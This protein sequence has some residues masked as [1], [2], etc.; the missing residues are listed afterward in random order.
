ML[1]DLAVL[2]V[3]AAV[4]VGAVRLLVIPAV[5]TIS[6]RFGFSS[7]LKGQ[8]IGYATSVPEFVVVIS[9]ALAGVF[10]A[11]FWNIASSNIINC[12]LFGSAV[13]AY[14]QHRDLPRRVFADETAFVVLSIAVP[15]ALFMLKV[16]VTLSAAWGLLGLFA[17]Y[18]GIDRAVN[19]RGPSPPSQPGGES[20]A[21]SLLKAL[22]A[23]AL[24]IGIV[25]VAGRFLGRSAHGLVTRLGTPAW[26]V[27][28]ILGFITSI[29]ELTSFFEIYRLHKKRKSLHL[30]LDT[31]EGLDALVASNMCNLGL[32]LPIGM[33]VY[34]WVR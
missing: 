28:W 15:A 17:A 22:V 16:Q 20:R 24:G 1:L 13:A 29:P 14:R 11:G 2:S 23:L 32:I 27:G 10:D 21:G 3:C 31:Q 18:K 12:V 5:E 4:T 7:K 33:F 19:P 6:T 34:A 25:I 30:L 8:I 26:C 9:S